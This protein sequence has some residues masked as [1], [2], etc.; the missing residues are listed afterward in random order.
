MP[1][2]LTKETKPSK[3]TTKVIGFVFLLILQTT[4]TY[5]GMLISAYLCAKRLS[6]F[7]LE[8]FRR[9]R[10]TLS[11]PLKTY[12]PLVDHTLLFSNRLSAAVVYKMFTF[13]RVWMGLLEYQLS[14][15]FSPDYQLS[16]K[17]VAKY[18]LSVK[19]R[20]YQLTLGGIIG[21][22]GQIDPHSIFLF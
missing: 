16:A 18:Q 13:M 21:R 4:T 7:I 3:S 12:I 17:N 8:L 22:R 15:K 20:D 5:A 19:I 9:V 14:A 6:R 2:S 10:P 11:W 1:V